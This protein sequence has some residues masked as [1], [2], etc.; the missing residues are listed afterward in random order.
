MMLSGL[1]TL[2]KFV[3][4]FYSEF[5]VMRSGQFLFPVGMYD[6]VLIWRQTFF[7][8][9]QLF[10]GLLCAQRTDAFEVVEALGAVAPWTAP[11]SFADPDGPMENPASADQAPA[12]KNLATSRLSRFP[13]T[14]R[15][16]SAVVAVV[17]PRYL[18]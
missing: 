16:C 3:V 1:I 5:V 17:Y 18:V 9:L 8:R 2:Y 4:R 14:D 11:R 10:T 12:A 13:V 7:V 6:D 15:K